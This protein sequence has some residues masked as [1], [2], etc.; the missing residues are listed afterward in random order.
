VEAPSLSKLH[1]REK[2]RIATTDV[3]LE[4]LRRHAFGVAYRMLGSVAEAED[5]AQETLLRFTRQTELIDEPAAWITT[6]TTRLSINVLKSARARREAYVGPWLPEPL[7]EDLMAPDP[8]ARAEVADSLSLA[9]LVLLERLNPVERAAYL[10]REVFNYSYSEIAK[11]I[12]QSEV[13]CRQIVARAR[14]HVEANRPRFDPDEALRDALLE[15]FL[16]AAENG[17]L[18][19]LESMLA[20]DA[21]LYADGGGKA[22]AVP[23][24]LF[25]R[26][27]IARFMAA[28]VRNDL[29][30]VPVRVNGQ[31]GRVVRG[32]AELPLTDA[33][34]R[35][36]EEA[37][38]AF[39]SGALEQ[40]ELEAMVDD[41]RR[42]RPVTTDIRIWSVLTVDVLDGRIHAIRIVRN[43][44]K[45]A[46]L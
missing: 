34:R 24:P 16:A 14:K 30:R 45:L 37:A 19:A 32:P 15:R 33:A 40:H 43:P 13:N 23:E 38:A 44:D 18:A 7:L 12:D 20:E 46:H 21:V 22:L 25:G 42:D 26:A 6:V 8:S 17:D 41:S 10:L 35:A 5:V 2:T 3:E 28:I 4:T 36:A 27:L 9:M 11:I 31:P 29:E 1:V 39:Q